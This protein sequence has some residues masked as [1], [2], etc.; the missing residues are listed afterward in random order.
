[1]SAMP[2]SCGRPLTLFLNAKGT[3]MTRSVSMDEVEDLL[4]PWGYY[5]LRRDAAQMIFR[6]QS[7][8]GLPGSDSPEDLTIRCKGNRVSAFSFELSFWKL[9][10]DAKR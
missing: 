10:I 2:R 7:N 3:A 1:M 5:F 6:H 8:V 4:R 9:C